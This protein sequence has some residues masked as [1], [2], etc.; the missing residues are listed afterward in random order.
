MT[1]TKIT[2]LNQLRSERT[3]LFLKKEVLEEAM[4]ENFRDLK[5]SLKPLNLIKEYTHIGDTDYSAAKLPKQVGNVGGSIL[6]LIVSGMLMKKA[7]FIKRIIAS[8][9][10]QKLAPVLINNSV[11]IFNDISKIIS[12]FQRKEKPQ[13]LFDQTTAHDLYSK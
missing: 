10:I 13:Q 9:L 4:T 1:T 2:S 5:E 8:T 6:N 11:P 7:G 12:N 3:R